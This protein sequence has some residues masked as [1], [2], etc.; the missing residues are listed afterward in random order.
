MISSNFVE[1]F[2]RLS[3]FYTNNQ[4]RLEMMKVEIKWFSKYLMQFVYYIFYVVMFSFNLL[5]LKDNDGSA[6]FLHIPRKSLVF[7]SIT[8]I[9]SSFLFTRTNLDCK[10]YIVTNLLNPIPPWEYG[11]YDPPRFFQNHSQTAFA[12]T[13]KLCEF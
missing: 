12:K 9:I 3:D 4:K 7:F 10:N 6:V 11:L 1:V 13:S 5:S 8:G 2:L